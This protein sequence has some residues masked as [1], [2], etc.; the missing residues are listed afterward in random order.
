M[1]SECPICKSRR[2]SFHKQGMQLAN[3]AQ[4]MVI[5]RS[6]T[7]TV[8]DEAKAKDYTRELWETALEK[9]EERAEPDSW[10]LITTDEFYIP[11][12]GQCS[13]S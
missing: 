12:P 7:D 8:F 11:G 10:P 5:S 6:P 13:V 9:A 1:T 2:K 4:R 3:I